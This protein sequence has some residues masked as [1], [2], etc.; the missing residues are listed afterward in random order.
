MA[1]KQMS[2]LGNEIIV[3]NDVGILVLVITIF[4]LSVQIFTAQF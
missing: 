4:D 1:W 2:F 3:A